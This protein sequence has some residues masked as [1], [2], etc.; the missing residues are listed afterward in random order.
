[1]VGCDHFESG[2]NLP[3]YVEARLVHE[4]VQALAVE[5]PLDFREDC[6]DWIEF[7]RV[8]DVPNGL[9]IKFGPPLFD[10]LLLMDV[11]IVHEQR[12]R[13]LA[14]LGAKLLEV[15][16]EVFAGARLIINPNKPNALFFGHGCDH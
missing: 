4:V 15:I 1:M 3:V 14:I 6:F 12:N 10:T 13:P 5:F 2:R 8:T 11:Q 7:R 16:A 9:H